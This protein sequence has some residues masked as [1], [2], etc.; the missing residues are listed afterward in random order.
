MSGKLAIG[1]AHADALQA[2]DL[3]QRQPRTVHVWKAPHIHAPHDLHVRSFVHAQFGLQKQVGGAARLSHAH[4]VKAR[5]E[6]AAPDHRA[7]VVADRLDRRVGDAHARPK[8][9]HRHG[10][11]GHGHALSLPQG[12]DRKRI[13]LD[14]RVFDVEKA[15]AIAQL[16]QLMEILR[17]ARHLSQHQH[18][19]SVCFFRAD[20]TEIAVAE[21]LRVR[22]L[23]NAGKAHGTDLYKARPALAAHV[24]RF[25]F[26]QGAQGKAVLFS[27]CRMSQARAALRILK[28]ARSSKKR[29]RCWLGRHPPSCRDTASYGSKPQGIPG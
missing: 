7:A 3:P 24:R 14:D 13:L 6:L 2:A 11:D 4:R 28:W 20:A 12:D 26:A 17:Q 27:P 1:F 22:D 9:Q 19:K 21:P 5:A 25:I 29:A 15:Q 16:R 10:G 18:S 23:Q 8:Q